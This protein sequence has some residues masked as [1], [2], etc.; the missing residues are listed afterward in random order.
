MAANYGRPKPVDP[1][2]YRFGWRLQARCLCGHAASE[3][4]QAFAPKR[5]LPVSTR[6]YQVMD[7]LRCSACG[8]RPIV[9]ELVSRS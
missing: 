6:L 9:A 2:W 1:L 7:R 8:Q 4:L 3:E 5:G